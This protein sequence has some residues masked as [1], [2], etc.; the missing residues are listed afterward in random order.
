MDTTSIEVINK[1]FDL[2]VNKLSDKLAK[3]YSMWS[4][5]IPLLI[6]AVLTLAVQ[7]LIEV[8]KTWKGNKKDKQAL[9]SRGRAKTYL[10]A[11]ILKDLALYMAH[12]EFY[13]RYESLDHNPIHKADCNKKRYEKGQEQRLA[14]AKLD[15]NIAEYFQIVTEYAILMHRVQCFDDLFKKIYS[16]KHP[17]V[18]DFNKYSTLQELQK[19]TYEAEDKLNAEYQIFN[20]SF[21][22][23]QELMT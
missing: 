8:Y 21:E 5:L 6:G 15:E 22:S 19:A 13:N 4:T 17:T 10:I 12:K 11:Q 2:F 16:Y 1:S 3:E 20:N 23:I 7:I 9:I 14:R 18:P